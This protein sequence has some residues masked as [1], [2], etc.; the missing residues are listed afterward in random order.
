[1]NK[2]KSNG[3]KSI[4]VNK[5]A[6][7]HLR[8]G[9][10]LHSRKKRARMGS[11]F[12]AAVFGVGVFISTV[13]LFI[14][15]G[16]YMLSNEALTLVGGTN[17]FAASSLKFDQKTGNYEYNQGYVPGS[18]MSAM[19]GSPRFSATFQAGTDHTT[20]IS[21]PVT[22]TAISIKPTFGLKQPRQEQ[23]RLLYPLATKN[24]VKVVS[25]ATI[26]FKEDIVLNKFQGDKLEFKYE[27]GLPEGTEARLEANG[28][29][30]IYGADYSLLGD[31]SVGSDSDKE[32]LEAARKN[33]IKRNLLFTFPAPFIK[34]YGVKK[35]NHNTWFTLDGSILTVHASNL[36][37]ASYPLT[38]DPSV[39]IET[40]AKLMR[41]NNETNISFD[42]D[43]ELIQKSQ[44][45]GAR[46]D[47]WN[48]NLDMSEG[49]WGHAS[50]AAG[51][52]LYRTG[53]RTGSTATKPQ[54]AEVTDPQ[55][56][57]SNTSNFTM[58]MPA[59]R[60][61]GD[62]Y[63]A[64]MC[65]DGSAGD[66]VG[67]SGSG[68]VISTPSGWT[69]YANRQGHAAYWKIGQN[70]S[71]GNEASS[72]TFSG[73]SEKWGG[74]IIRVTGFN[75]SDPINTSAVTH[76]TSNS[77][78]PEFPSVTPDEDSTLI[79]RAVGADND[80]VTNTTWVPPGHTSLG[81]GG[82][83]GTQDCAYVAASLDSSPSAGVATGSTSILSSITDDY[84]ASSIAI[85]PAVSSN[86]PENKASVNW[87]RF[88]PSSH[89]IESPNPGNGA[90]S[91]WCTNSEYDLP[92]PRLGHSMVAYNGYLYVMGGIDSSCTGALNACS[93]V[94]IAKIGANGEP[95]LWHPTDTNPD[96]WV[97]WYAD[98]GLSGG[99][100]RRYAAATAYNNRM[101]LIG[102]QTN[103]ASSGVTSVEMA[104]ILPNGKL[105]S[106]TTSGMQSLPAGAGRY[107]H[108]I[109]VYNDTLYTLGGFEGAQT[110]SANLRNSVYYSKLNSDGTMNNWSQTS[111]IANDLNG[112]ATPR[113][114]FGG[115]FSAIWGGYLY[116]GGGCLAVNASG[117][118]TS[119]ASD[120]QL[121]S[122]NADGTLAE[123]NHMLGLDHTRIGHTFV[124][125]QDGLYRLGGCTNV[126]STTGE[127]TGTLADVDYG[128]IN[129][130][131]EASTV[132]NSTASGAVPGTCVSATWS[133][134][135]MPGT[136]YI[137]NMLNAT[138]ILNGY[139]Y[140]I[141]GC[142]NTGCSSTSGNV[143]YAAIGSDGLLTRPATCPGGSIQGGMWCVDTTRTI[144]G[145]IAAAGTAVFNNR[146]YLVGGQSSSA[147]KGN[148][149][150]VG[151]NADGSLASA[152]TAQSFSAIAATSVSY[153]FAYARANPSAASTYPGNLFIFGG[154]SGSSGGIGCTSGSN[155]QAV[156]KCNITPSGDLEEANAN[157]CDTAGQLQL[158]T[159]P[160]AS[161]PGLALH[162]GTVYANYIYLMGGVSPDYVDQPLVR[163]AKFD[164]NNN[165][166]AVPAGPIP[167]CAGNPNGRTSAD[168]SSWVVS[169][170][171]LSVGRRRGTSF[172]YNGYF[173][174]VGGYDDTGGG[175]LSD[176]QFA[177]FNVSTGSLDPFQESS[178]TINQRWG[179]SVPVSNSYAFVI[180]G[181]TVGAS[182]SCS[183][184]T[185]SV[186]TFQVYN[187][188]SGAVMNF[189]AQSDDT[190]STSSDRIGASAAVHDGKLYVAGGCTN[191]TCTAVTDN[192]QVATISPSDGSVGTWASTT[193]STL[194]AGRAWGQLEVAGGTLYYI[195]GQS[196]S[197]TDE[198]PE[199]YY[200]TPSGGNVSAWNTVNSSFDLP[201]GRTRHGAAV[202]NNRLY[203]VGGIAQTGGNVSS[204][205]YVSPSLASGG[206]IT[207]AWSTSSPNFNVAR[208]GAAVVAY[209]NNLYLF[210]GNDGTNY[211]SDSQ[212]A[213]IDGATGNVSSWTYTTS[214]PTPIS[215]GRAVAANGYIYI[216]GGRSAA[217]T[218]TPNTLITPVSANT[219]IASGNNPTGI[220]EWYETNIRY[221]GDRYGSA[222]AYDKG[223]LYT[224]GGGC[225]SLLSANRHYYSTVKS[226]PQVAKYSRM[227]DTDTD[228]FPNSWL[229]NGVDNSIG[230]RWTARYRSMHD[231][232]TLV[233][234]NEDCGTSATMPTMTTWGQDTNFGDVALGT[235]NAFTPKNSSGQN[236]NCARYYYFFISIDASQTF[237]YPEDVERGPTI[238]DL[239]L[240]FTSD[241]SRR[242]RHGKTFTG[243][244]QQPLDTPCRREDA[245]AGDPNYHCPLP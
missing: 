31:V 33:A 52:Y 163:Y 128:V 183:T 219:T 165:V 90:C 186:Q 230:A 136:T 101:Y 135:D 78:T 164:N 158:G 4:R 173:Y 138:A 145:G 34:E 1:M 60:P 159:T 144:S 89:E 222:I 76:S 19:G 178:V 207:S 137:G 233:N 187:N 103:A 204:T 55:L 131:G 240:F 29:L 86:T 41:G 139:L 184:A 85:N 113:A 62:L 53:G 185:N 191:I 244:E 65:Y 180:G 157:D 130:D 18:E 188:D 143:A 229:M 70:I 112:N 88:N 36:K 176:I 16:N 17:S 117:Y 179:L 162:S 91:G 97:Y 67:G 28:S 151:I 172:G 171:E 64:I 12:L 197:A 20:V 121:A 223:K 58:D 147:L 95:Q 154:C 23:N 96:N 25:M 156:Y 215:E 232:D 152:W 104:D 83:T 214:L 63:I 122:I 98:S 242:L 51:G 231:L 9:A 24:A 5:Y 49:T 80:E 132:A 224:M 99:T 82:P 226:Q 120:V 100:G 160:G 227:I 201:D 198:R 123:W 73:D 21:D 194:P 141:G 57:N 110:S 220:G 118:C 125:W 45:T 161:G 81:Y 54:I 102:G 245:V 105:G 7:R 134:C 192:V 50:A 116:V 195:G 221:T 189:N 40:A 126:S 11:F 8:L 193:D 114:N 234:P 6:P 205:V 196:A 140:V 166:V 129:P 168:G 203:V 213:K 146:I 39:Y 13:N 10:W 167:T 235:V 111:S 37:D 75:T 35:V 241:P 48:N 181:C 175:V 155:T 133:N 243:G 79:I 2:I 115:G 71:G 22:K 94:Y 149:Y 42:T 74:I 236:I 225:S 142:T 119:I 43:N 170:H 92:N 238:A 169:C 124:A 59:N 216:V 106:W 32:L 182:P 26:G 30:A 44:T 3:R 93:T 202:W 200:G 47:G 177:K 38:I 66:G 237:G 72:Y 107:M 87:A 56:A 77:A 206:D 211:F 127:C 208:S 27:L 14:E 68:N 218:C 148:V 209:A 150:H 61:A 15:S 212:F 239:S 174:A 210:G 109:E 108:S 69:K 217:S 46:I 228:V 153:T 190:F 84:G 199:I